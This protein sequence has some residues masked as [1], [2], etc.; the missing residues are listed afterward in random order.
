M[1]AAPSSKDITSTSRTRHR[2]N[3][4]TLVSSQCQVQLSRTQCAGR[5]ILRAVLAAKIT[6]RQTVEDVCTK[7]LHADAYSRY[8][9][10][11]L[12]TNVGLTVVGIS[13]SRDSERPQLVLLSSS[14]FEAAVPALK[15]AVPLLEAYKGIV[16]GTSG[17]PFAPIELTLVPRYPKH[18]K[19][20][21]EIRT[22]VPSLSSRE[23]AVVREFIMSYS[24]GST[25]VRQLIESPDSAGGGLASAAAFTKAMLSLT[26]Y[27]IMLHYITEEDGGLG[28]NHYARVV[29]SKLLV[30]RIPELKKMFGCLT[31]L[32]LF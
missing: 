26:R 13:L 29:D 20:L 16:L 23:E 31:G 19:A 28:A 15:H 12:L 3:V 9:Y 17:E 25:T 24:L 22:A 14:L 18:S 6:P 32:A 30:R 11:S 10:Q 8:K 2:K 4:L 1:P 7:L 21:C 5:G 27:G